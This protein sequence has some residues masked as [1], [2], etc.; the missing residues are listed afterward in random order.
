MNNYELN[1]LFDI[2]RHIL[3]ICAGVIGSFFPNDKSNSN[4]YLN[5]VL[6]ACFTV[7]FLYGDLDEGYQYT[8]SDI[9]FWLVVIIEGF[10]GAYLIT[11]IDNK[12]N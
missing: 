12:C 9:V 4:P 10:I 7:K 2:K 8:F 1:N 11:N 6:I 5:G 3:A